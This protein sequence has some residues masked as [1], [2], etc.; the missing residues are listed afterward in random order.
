MKIKNNKDII[1]STA[2]SILMIIG[3]VIIVIN[4]H[5]YAEKSNRLLKQDY[6]Q[7]M[8]MGK[9]RYAIIVPK[10]TDPLTANIQSLTVVY[11]DATSRV[12]VPTVIYNPYDCAVGKKIAIFSSKKAQKINKRQE[13]IMGSDIIVGDYLVIQTDEEF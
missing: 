10:Q 6:E 13:K 7:L 3:F 4:T 11:D 12:I 1:M 5:G 2:V 8:D 9:V